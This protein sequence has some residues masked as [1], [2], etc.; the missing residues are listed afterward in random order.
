MDHCNGNSN[1]SGTGRWRAPAASL[2]ST[3]REELLVHP[4]LGASWEGFALAGLVGFEGDRAFWFLGSA[5]YV[6]HTGERPMAVVWQLRHSLPGGSVCVVC[7]RRGLKQPCYVGLRETT[8]VRSSRTR[9]AAIAVTFAL[10]GKVSAPA[11]HPHAIDL[12]T[13]VRGPEEALLR[14]RAE[15]LENQ[16]QEEPFPGSPDLGM[17]FEVP[18]IADPEEGMQ[19]AGIG[20]VDLRGLD[21]ALADARM[22]GREQPDDECGAQQVEVMPDRLVSHPEGSCELGGVPHLA[23]VVGQHRP[24]TGERGTGHAHAQLRKVPLD[25]GADELTPPVQASGVATTQEEYMK[26]RR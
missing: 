5:T 12:R 7:C 16:L 10:S 26:F 20:D 6:R 22:P 19:D 9:D 24:E 15:V 18:G 3:T 13:G 25:E 11:P 2:G 14:C 1:A 4:K 17:P 23:V 21:L 8:H